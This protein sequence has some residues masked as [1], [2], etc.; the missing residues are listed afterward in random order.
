M[1]PYVGVSMYWYV[2]VVLTPFR[3]FLKIFF[4]CLGF[5]FFIR[6]GEGVQEHARTEAWM[7]MSSKPLAFGGSEVVTINTLEW[8]QN[9]NQ[10]ME[11]GFVWN[12]RNGHMYI[13]LLVL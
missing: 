7:L 1:Y 2:C 11:F 13:V 6:R 9:H 3:N 4:L 5:A 12:I 8:V 10:I